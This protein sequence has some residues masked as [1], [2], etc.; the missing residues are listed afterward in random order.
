MT[1]GLLFALLSLVL[2]GIWGF[3]Y[4]LL[5]LRDIQGAWAVALIMLLGAAISAGIA[6]ARFEPF[7]AA[8]FGS[9]VPWIVVVAL[10]GAVGNI[11]L[12]KAMAAPGM[13]S[14]V[15]MAITGAYPLV[16]ALLAWVFLNE[17]LAGPQAIGI[18]AIVFGVGLLT[19]K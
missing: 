15:V 7:P 13:S 18:A 8:K 4:K 6:L 14:G 2:Y 10:S 19:F 3:S 5:A 16:V 9:N 11:F 12:T 1:Q 17:Q